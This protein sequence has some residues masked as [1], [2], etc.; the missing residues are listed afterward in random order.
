MCSEAIRPGIGRRAR[1]P[2]KGRAMAL[3]IIE[4]KLDPE[5]ELAK[6]NRR[7]L[8]GKN[9]PQHLADPIETVAECEAGIRASVKLWVDPRAGT[10]LLSMEYSDA[11]QWT[12]KTLSYIMRTITQIAS[13]ETASAKLPTLVLTGLSETRQP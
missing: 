7:Y 2:I 13:G 12:P 6:A 8:K 10:L 5:G 11:G 9:L 1:A 3:K 4:F